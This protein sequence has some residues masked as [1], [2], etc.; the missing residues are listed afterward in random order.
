MRGISPVQLALMNRIRTYL[1]KIWQR[2][3]R[4]REERTGRE[5]EIILYLIVRRSSYKGEQGRREDRI[6]RK[7]GVT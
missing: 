5:R 1:W 4:E 3:E 6:E 2:G 7:E